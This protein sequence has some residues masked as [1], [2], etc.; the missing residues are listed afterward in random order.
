MS[1]LPTIYAKIALILSIIFLVGGVGAA[2]AVGVMW[3]KYSRNE[4]PSEQQFSSFDKRLKNIEKTL[5]LINKTLGK[6]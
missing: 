1:E 2:I 6:K 5:K 4:S 3:F